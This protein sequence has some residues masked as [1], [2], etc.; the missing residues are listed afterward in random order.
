MRYRS[1][2]VKDVTSEQLL[3]ELLTR[4]G[5]MESEERVEFYDDYLYCGVG[6]GKDD[7]AS[8]YLPVSSK[9]ILDNLIAEND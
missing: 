9:E 3:F 1:E 5:T 2:K 6:V 7:T 4:E 8:I